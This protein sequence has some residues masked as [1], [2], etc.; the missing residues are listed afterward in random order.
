MHVLQM[1]N[2]SINEETLPGELVT[3]HR[4]AGSEEDTLSVSLAIVS[5]KSVSA[6][7]VLS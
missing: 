2:N 3:T 5:V 4:A 7:E 6:Q 1:A